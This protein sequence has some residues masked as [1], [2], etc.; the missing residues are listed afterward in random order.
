MA[1]RRAIASAHGVLGALQLVP[2]SD[3]AREDAEMLLKRL[4]GMGV[5]R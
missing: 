5:Q 2:G 3:G 4:M 1:L